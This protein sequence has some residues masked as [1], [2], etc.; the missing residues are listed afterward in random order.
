M[1][2]KLVSNSQP[3]GLPLLPRLEYSSTISAHCSLHSLAQAILPPQSP[4]GNLTLLP[5]QECSGT[6]SAHCNLRL[7]GSSDSSAS[8]S[9]VAETR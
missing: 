9:R 5:R 4:E 7:P 8:A 2:V 3:Q 1:L 6:I